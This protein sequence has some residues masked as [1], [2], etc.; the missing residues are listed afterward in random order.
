AGWLVEPGGGIGQPTLMA[1]MPDQ[2][3][4]LVSCAATGSVAKVD[5]ATGQVIDPAFLTGL[6]RPRGIAFDQH[7]NIYVANQ[8]DNTINRYTT[9]GRPLPFALTGQALTTPFGL[10]FD[11]NGVL[12]VTPAQAAVVQS[13]TIQG[14]TGRVATFATGQANP[15]GLVFNGGQ[16][17]PSA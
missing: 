11:A 17:P 10:A 8:G 9:D 1:M 12:Y 14:N 4:L 6:N 2:S 5:P 13:V 3:A 16:V 15:G 7:W